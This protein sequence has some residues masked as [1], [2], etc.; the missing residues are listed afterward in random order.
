MKEGDEHKVYK[1]KKALYGLK[2][3]PRA[4]YSRI[5]VYFEKAGFHKCPYEHT[6][7]IKT[8]EGGKLLIVCLYVDDL[9]FTR[10]DE[11][12]IAD[13]K[14]SM[15]AEFDMT[16]LGKMRYF[17]DIEVVQT[18]TR[19]FIGQKKYAQEVLDRFRMMNCNQVGTP[20]EPG[21]KLTDDPEGKKIDNTYFK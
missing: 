2:Q 11:D 13:F 17:L 20:S 12:M 9:I 19:I 5:E 6:L 7:F 4:W 8:K 1:L 16:D 18:P 21:L 15:M 10:N 14:N 3:A